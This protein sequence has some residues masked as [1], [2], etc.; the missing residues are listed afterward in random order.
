MAEF[1]EKVVSEAVSVPVVSLYMAPPKVVEVFWER[2]ELLEVVSEPWLK[3][4][5]PEAEVLEARPVLERVKV[6]EVAL[7]MAPPEVV[8]SFVVKIECE[9]RLLE[10]DEVL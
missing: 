10:S 1:W 3:M 4:A 6:A 7:N 5:A 8:A 9:I 2:V